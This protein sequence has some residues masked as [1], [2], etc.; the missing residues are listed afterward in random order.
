MPSVVEAAGAHRPTVHASSWCA[1]RSATASRT[2]TINRPDAMN[3]L[4][5]EVVAQLE[6]GFAA[7]AS[8][9]A[10][11]GIVIAGS[12]K[13]FVAGADIR[14]F[15]RN[16]ESGAHRSD[17]GVHAPRPGAAARVRN[18]R[19][20]GDR[21]R[22]RPRARRRRRARARVPRDRRDAEGH[23][24]VSRDRH[25]HL[26]RPRR[27]PAHD[28]ARRHRP[29]EVAGADRPDA[30]RRRGARDRPRRRRRRRPSSSTQRSPS[31]VANGVA[32]RGRRQA[33]P[34]GTKRSP[35]SSTATPRTRSA[36]AA[37]PT[38]AIRSSRRRSR[39][40]EQKRQSRCASPP[41]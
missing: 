16:I 8:D 36:P 35:T 18:L 14:F 11:K 37:R 20:A 9:P 2:L 6:A 10:V 19:Q 7:L 28:A 33:C 26:P 38:P 13:A 15:V 30:H 39:R 34:P 25:R 3:A 22:P 27:H 23:V 29:G 31:I 40:W 32:R 1:R 12:G 5:E 41:I 17:R 4:N 21:P 24:R